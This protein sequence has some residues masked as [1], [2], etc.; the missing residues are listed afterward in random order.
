MNVLPQP[1]RVA[2]LLGEA[3]AHRALHHPYLDALENGTLPDPV[4]ALPQRSMASPFRAR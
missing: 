3:E 2:M 4:D 1:S